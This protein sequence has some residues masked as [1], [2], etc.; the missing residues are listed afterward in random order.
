[1]NDFILAVYA[2]NKTLL[3]LSETF[4]VTLHTMTHTTSS[5]KIPDEI[6]V[7]PPFLPSGMP[8]KT[9][10]HIHELQ[11]SFECSFEPLKDLQFVNASTQ[12]AWVY[13]LKLSSM[14]Y[15][16]ETLAEA[17]ASYDPSIAAIDMGVSIDLINTLIGEFIDQFITTLP[18]IYHALAND[19]NE[20]LHNH[21]HKLKG[22]AS[23]LH[24]VEIA[25]DISTTE[26]YPSRQERLLHIQD[27]TTKVE[28]LAYQYGITLPH[29]VGD[30]Y[31]EPT[32]TI[33]TP[34]PTL[35]NHTFGTYDILKT[36]PVVGLSFE[37]L[38]KYL[39]H[40]FD[41]VNEAYDAIQNQNLPKAF[42]LI[43]ESR[44]LCDILL[45][46]D[47]SRHL[48]AMLRDLPH[49]TDFEPLLNFIQVLKQQ[50]AHALK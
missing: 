46:P 11:Q 16:K 49:H 4:F 20:V 15:Q 19:K 13:T 6:S 37:Q 47:L 5:L 38:T 21:L 50:I 7:L 1:M 36:A 9:T 18:H 28:N 41:N 44:R 48:D 42:A 12:S 10:F 34:S 40:L 17:Q 32:S 39:T 35:E 14:T 27:L 25:N 31:T 43:E 22:A 33:I 23:S 24:L 2:T 3:A 26:S 29:S 45:L 30:N 8:W